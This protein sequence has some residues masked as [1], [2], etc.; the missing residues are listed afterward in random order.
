ME[1]LPVH[2]QASKS[3]LF[4]YCDGE[5]NLTFKVKV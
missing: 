1:S 3:C 4:L 5:K 2:L